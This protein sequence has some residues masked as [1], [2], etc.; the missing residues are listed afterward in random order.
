MAFKDVICA[1]SLAASRRKGLE[2]LLS[3]GAAMLNSLTFTTSDLTF[4]NLSSE[5]L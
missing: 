5:V 4:T 2:S 3:G 1:Y